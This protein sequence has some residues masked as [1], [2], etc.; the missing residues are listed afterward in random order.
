MG[1]YNFKLFD[2]RKSFN[3]EVIN[4]PFL[5]S[6]IPDNVAYGVFVSQLIPL[7]QVNSNIHNLCKTMQNIYDATH[8]L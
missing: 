6:N 2:K 1:K 7:C 8:Y 3:F 5:P 4:Y